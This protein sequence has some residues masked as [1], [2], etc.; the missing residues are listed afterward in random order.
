MWF[1][2]VILK[3]IYYFIYWWLITIPLGILNG[4]KSVLIEL[5]HTLVLR[6]NF[7]LWL[8]AEP[9]FGDYTWQGRLVGFFLRG[10][11]VICSIVA[12][13]LIVLLGILIIVGWFIAP[14]FLFKVFI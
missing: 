14:I 13:L 11:R 2:L 8:V 5:D 3:E 4:I 10:L 9:M 12:Y 6:E 1:G 7:R